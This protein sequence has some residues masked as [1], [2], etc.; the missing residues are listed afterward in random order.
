MRKPA[1]NRQK[2]LLKFFGIRFHP[3]IS[4]GGAGWEISDIFCDEENKLKWRKYL[5]LTHD[6]GT[7]SEDLVPYDPKELENVNVPEDWKARQAIREFQEDLVSEIIKEESPYDLPQP[8]IV[9]AKRSFCFTGKFEYGSR[10]NCENSVK[11]R[12][13]IIIK[14]VS[15]NL[16]YLVVGTQGSPNWKRGKYGRKIESAILLRREH[17][18]PAIVSEE[19]WIKYL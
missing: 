15:S 5:Y 19:H 4:F 7:N 6:F 18:N 14:T 16:D 12:G 11:E 17:G 9:I 3:S 8:E 1:T 2:K 13:G 10:E